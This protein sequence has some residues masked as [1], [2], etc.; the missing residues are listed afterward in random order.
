MKLIELLQ[1]NTILILLEGGKALKGVSEISQAEVRSSAP[2]I[3]KMIKDILKL[4]ASKVKIIGSAGKKSKD[5]D[6]SGDIDIAVECDPSLI[7]ENLKTLAGEHTS[8]I[9]KGIGVFSFAHDVGDKLVQIDL[10]PVNNINFAEWSFQA[11]PIDIL[12]GLK[13]AQRNELFFAIAKYM[14]QKVLR[15]GANGEVISIERYF[16]DLARGLMIGTRTRINAK[17]KIGKNFITVDKKVLSDDPEKIT[18]LMFGNTV[19]PKQVST[20][21]GTLDA[22]KSPKFPLSNKVEDI[23]KQSLTGIKNKNL[24]IPESL[25]QPS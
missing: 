22:I 17:E 8:R 23:L 19:T 25:R 15:R 6:M 16:Y 11:N 9:M 2:S 10:M 24:K 14:P 21:D 3:L 20:F 7:E 13:G 12:Q 5:S 4:P 18:E 1:Q